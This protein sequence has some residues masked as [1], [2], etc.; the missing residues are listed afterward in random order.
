MQLAWLDTDSQKVS[1]EKWRM[2]KF[3]ILSFTVPNFSSYD[4]MNLIH[5]RVL[6]LYILY[7]GHLRCKSEKFFGMIG[8]SDK[9]TTGN[10][11]KSHAMIRKVAVLAEKHS[12][13]LGQL[14]S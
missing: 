13:W 6:D 3:D 2:P 8:A 10:L 5:S 9:R 12:H 14:A 1:T 11:R 7:I 4:A